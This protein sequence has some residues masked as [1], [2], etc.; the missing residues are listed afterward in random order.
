[1]KRINGAQRGNSYNHI[2]FFDQDGLPWTS[3]LRWGIILFWVAS[4]FA[5][6]APLVGI[7]LSVWLLSKGR[8]ALSL[9][10]YLALSVVCVPVFLA[11]FPS[12]G[13]M[14]SVEIAFDVSLMVLWLASAFSLR[15]EV[16]LYYSGREGIPFPLN[17]ILTALLG[18]WYVGGHLRPDF[19]FDDS[20][21]VGEGI[22]KLTV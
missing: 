4:I 21:K 1:M 20:G 8:S 2:R 12:R 10:L 6:L 13:V 19:P 18:P 16:I 3:R 15:H 14:S 22:L 9:I 7:Y 17:P 11:S 5:F